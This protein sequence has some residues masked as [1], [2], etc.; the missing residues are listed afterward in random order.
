MASAKTRQT[1]LSASVALPQ[2]A[3]QS[4]HEPSARQAGDS[5]EALM[6]AQT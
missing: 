3:W 6:P 5:P 1:A 2:Q 4:I